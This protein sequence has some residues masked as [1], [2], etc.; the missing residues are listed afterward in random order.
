[1]HAQERSFLRERYDAP[2]W[3]GRSRYDTQ[4]IKDVGFIGLEIPGWVLHRSR[5]L[6]SN[7][8]TITKSIW[9]QKNDD[10]TLIAVDLY[11][12]SSVRGAHDRLLELLGSMQS[13]NVTRQK[14]KTI[15]ADVRFG[16]DSTMAVLSCANF[17]ALVRN[18]GSKI[19]NVRRPM[20]A[21]EAFLTNRLRLKRS[22]IR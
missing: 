15:R 3:Y 11:A 20:S 14:S 13:P 8:T 17:V 12:C 19:V 5:Q 9:M 22:K 21:V 10:A 1:M 16:Y 4:R 7:T 6:Q 18:A 2:S